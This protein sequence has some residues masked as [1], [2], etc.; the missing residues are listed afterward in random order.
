MDVNPSL[1][2]WQL[3]II[4]M[5]M[6]ILL[7]CHCESGVTC[8]HWLEPTNLDATFTVKFCIGIPVDLSW[9]G[10]IS[11]IPFPLIPSLERMLTRSLE[12][13][14]H[15]HCPFWQVKG[16][17]LM[18]S[19]QCTIVWRS[20]KR[21]LLKKQLL[22][23]RLIFSLPLGECNVIERMI[24][25]HM[26]SDKTDFLDHFQ[27]GFRPVWESNWFCSSGWWPL[28]VELFWTSQYL[29]MAFRY[30]ARYSWG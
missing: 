28:L 10:C 13:P 4:L 30:S 12:I 20:L 21:T 15:T 14:L 24:T 29:L 2:K 27:Y 23:Y 11:L 3:N 16:D 26:F 9:L 17:Y 22:N 6:I 19:G 5:K 25:G 7:F 1:P 8:C 18:F